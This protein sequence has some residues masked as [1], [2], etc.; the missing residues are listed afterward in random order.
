MH[1]NIIFGSEIKVAPLQAEDI[2]VLLE[3]S[4]YASWRQYPAYCDA[5]AQMMDAENTYLQILW[6][7]QVIAIVNVRIKR[8]PMLTWGI[9]M[10]AQGPVMMPS[11]VHYEN[12]PTLILEALR[13]YLTMQGLTLRINPPV[14][15]VIDPTL[16]LSSP[17]GFA[18]ISNSGYQTFIIDIQPSEDKLRA[19]LVGK[20]R[21]DLRRGE[22]EDV[23]IITSQKPSDFRLFQPLLEELSAQKGFDTPQDAEFFAR[24]AERAV[25]GEDFTVHLAYSNGLLVGGHIGAYS[26]NVAVY[27]LGATNDEGRNLRVS[28][29]L[30]WAA[31]T[32]AKKC[33]M[34]HYDLGGVDE[35]ANP[36]VF[37]FKKRMGGQ[38]YHGP[39]M[40]EA[41]A[42][43]I[44]GIVVSIAEKLYQAIKR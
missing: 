9:A 30:Q 6:E 32:Y 37:R 19:N 40:I 13:S 27:L 10:I 18:K 38:Y 44:A 31:I 16:S 17:A 24:C 36:D 5:A 3:R 7:D 21:T 8:L 20:W 12:S 29:I 39:L 15:G 11:A 22:K 14:T 2:I 28:Y 4:E 35:M 41:R 33:G 42:N 43:G 26:G 23:T 25:D 34:T 1:D